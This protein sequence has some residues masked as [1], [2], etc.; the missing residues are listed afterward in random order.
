MLLTKGIELALPN[1]LSLFTSELVDMM[2][3]GWALA[4]TVK[5]ELT[6]LVMHSYKL[7]ISR[8]MISLTRSKT[9]K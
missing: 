4:D 1:Y 3:T 8:C 5:A 2:A 7:T 9:N 6:H